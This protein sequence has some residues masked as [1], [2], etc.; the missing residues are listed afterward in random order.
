MLEETSVLGNTFHGFLGHFLFVVMP[1]GAEVGL[2]TGLWV[3]GE[4][5]G[6]KNASVGSIGAEVGR[7]GFSVGSTGADVGATGA[8]EGAIGASVG[9]IGA[10]VGAKEQRVESK[11]QLQQNWEGSKLDRFHESHCTQNICVRMVVMTKGA[12]HS[13]IKDLPVLCQYSV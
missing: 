10:V 9:S 6:S 8:A 3:T 13:I 11:F 4:E 1:A 5:I 7:I 2:A 12:E